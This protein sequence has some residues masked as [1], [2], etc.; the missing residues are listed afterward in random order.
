MR[1]RPRSSPPRWPSPTGICRGKDWFA[2]G[3]MTIADIALAPI[4]KRCLGF[5]IERPAFPNLDRWMASD[6]L[7]PR[8]P[9][10]DR[11][12]AC[13]VRRLMRGGC[14]PGDDGHG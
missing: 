10:G 14:E 6:R 3:R 2:L 1:R 12:E 11:R 4:F 8:F 5:P 13:R 9:V 7:A